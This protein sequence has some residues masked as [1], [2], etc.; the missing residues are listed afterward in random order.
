MG[1]REL[2]A[3]SAAHSIV[4]KLYY[5]H[6]LSWYLYKFRLLIVNVDL[7]KNRY[8]SELDKSEIN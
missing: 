3:W 7:F 8:V 5:I 1:A 2:G 6:S 4:L